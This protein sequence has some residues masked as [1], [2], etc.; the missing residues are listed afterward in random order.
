MFKRL[1]DDAPIDWELQGES[2]L[3][4]A[5]IPDPPDSTADSLV[6]ITHTNLYGPIDFMEFFVR[7]GDPDNPTEQN[8]ITAHA[9]WAKLEL[10]EEVLGIED[11]DGEEIDILR[12]DFEGELDPFEEIM[13]DGTFDAKLKLR[14][15]MNSIEIKAL[16]H[17]EK[18][19]SFILAGWAVEA[20]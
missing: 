10:V 15:G 20:S 7:L 5:V 19:R 11:D 2:T 4:A 16:S 17:A 1:D 8:D 6:R 12:S 9:D 3:R 14:R 18:F 13:W